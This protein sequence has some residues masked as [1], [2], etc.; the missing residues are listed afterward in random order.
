MLIIVLLS[1]TLGIVFKIPN[2]QATTVRSFHLYGSALSGWGFTPSTLTI[3]GPTIEL[4]QGDT[5]NLTLTSA[6]GPHQFYVDYNGDE[7]PNSLM[8]PASGFFTATTINFQ[9]TVSPSQGN[10]TYYCSFHQGTM[11]GLFRVYPPGGIP[12]F[13]QAI[14]LPLFIAVTLLAA[15]IVHKRR[16]HS[17]AA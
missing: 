4:E 16:K 14:I 13:P 17:N 8:E 2:A 5:A 1:G 10:F 3:P 9:F 6:D 12:E 11:H 7:I 15:A